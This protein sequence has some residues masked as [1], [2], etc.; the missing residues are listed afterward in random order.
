MP[1]V[2]RHGLHNALCQKSQRRFEG[3]KFMQGATATSGKEQAEIEEEAAVISISTKLLD[4]SFEKWHQPE[5]TDSSSD[6]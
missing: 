4:L 6:F 1:A 5:S 2:R 3:N